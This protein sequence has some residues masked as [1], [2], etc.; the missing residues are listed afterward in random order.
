MKHL[1][2]LVVPLLAVMMC[3]HV[4]A[5]DAQAQ[6]GISIAGYDLN[7]YQ[8]LQAVGPLPADFKKSLD[9]LYGED[10]QRVRDYADGKLK[11]ADKVLQASYYINGLMTS[12][13]VVYGD[14]ISCLVERVA[15]TL[16]H[17]YPELRKELRFY[18]V[19][20]AAVN[21]F[22]TG[23]GIIFVNAGLV[24]QLQNEAQLAYILSHEIVHFL[25]KHNWEQITIKDDK[26][27]RDVQREVSSFLRMHN[28]SRQM[29]SQADS[30]GLL[31]FFLPSSYGAD[32]VNGVFDVLQYSYLPFDEVALDAACFNTA[33]YKLPGDCFLDKVD[34]I[35]ATDD[36]DDSKSTHPN[37]LKRRNMT[38]SLIAQTAHAGQRHYLVSTAAEFAQIRTLARFECVRQDM[39]SNDFARAF[40]N[41][42][43]MQ[44]TMPD[45]GYLQQA[46]AHSLYALSRYKT[47]K[48]G[49]DMVDS[50]KN[51]EGESQQA[52]YFMHKVSG[53]DLAILALRQVWKAHRAEPAD[54]RLLDMASAL[55]VDIKSYYHLAPSVFSAVYDTAAVAVDT[56]MDAQQNT[57]YDRIKAKRRNQAAQNTRCYA[58]TDLMQADSSFYPF[59]QRAQ[60]GD[61]SFGGTQAVL[62][63]NP[64]YFCINGKSEELR[65]KRS[66]AKRSELAP[67][68]SSLLRRDGMRVEERDARW[69]QHMTGAEEYNEF[70]TM[71]DWCNEFMLSPNDY[72]RSFSTQ[73]DMLPILKN[74][75]ANVVNITTVATV[76]R[77]GGSDGADDLRN[78]GLLG[79]VVLVPLLPVTIYGLFASTHYTMVSSYFVDATNGRVLA[80]EV[81]DVEMNDSRA[82][83]NSLLYRGSCKL[84]QVK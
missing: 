77:T 38:A 70:L 79:V 59:L 21:A 55:A 84:Q 17:D 53:D 73:N 80:K 15:D 52:Y 8:G 60:A 20:S 42:Y 56:A 40:Y 19:K 24:A 81:S 61:T 78:F 27:S 65:V 32:V 30:L 29:E 82:V 67:L 34:P 37:L 31:M 10:R 57:K 23:Q 68:L 28:R 54:Q 44:K 25:K 16:L 13:R 6:P 12:G 18:T 83:V 47:V 48:S 4:A 76:N 41:S 64:S 46:M 33:Y 51:H 3:C 49:D 45:N 36:Y 63:C 66:D 39:I 26:N 14:P 1:L 2:P 74:H 11:N 50:Y 58:F 22:A 5:Q 43:V 9:D 72:I 75:R 35:T 62:I 71:S 7:H 69:L